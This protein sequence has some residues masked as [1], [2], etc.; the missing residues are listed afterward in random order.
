MD[1]DV[2]HAGHGIGHP[3]RLYML[4]SS[5]QSLSLKD[6]QTILKSA[7]YVWCLDAKDSVPKYDGNYD[8]SSVEFVLNDETVEEMRTKVKSNKLVHLS[9]G[10]ASQSSTEK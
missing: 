10:A 8:D 3:K 4:L 1:G 2:F 7:K 5:R 6:K 9:P